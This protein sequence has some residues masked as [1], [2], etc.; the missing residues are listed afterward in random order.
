MTNIKPGA[1]L[2]KEV[3]VK[4]TGTLEASYNLIWQ[5]LNNGITNDEMVMSATCE[6]QN[7]S[8]T[9][10]GTCEGLSETA[11]GDN[12]I[13]K[14]ITIESG[15]THKY[16]ITIT[17]KDT[18]AEQNYNQGKSFTGVLG[19]KE[20]NP[21]EVEVLNCTFDG[22]MVQGAEYVNGQY[23]YRYKQKGSS[24]FSTKLSWANM[25]VDGWGVQL[26]DKASTNPVTSKICTYINNKPVVSMSTMFLYSNATSIDL[27]SFDTSDVTDMFD[28]F[29]K[30]K[31]TVLDV[32]N[33]DTSKVTNMCGMFS[34]TDALEIKGL[35]NFNTSNVTN[36]C[37]MFSSSQAKA[38]NLSN[39]DTSNVRNMNS[40]FSDS[41]ATEIKGLDKFNTSNVTDMEYMF[42]GSKLTTIDL[43]NFDTSNVTIMSY[44]FNASAA[45]TIDLS[46]FNTNKVE[47]MDHMFSNCTSLKTIFASDKFVT[48]QLPTM[49]DMG[50]NQVNTDLFSGSTNL[51]GGN[52]TKFNSSY[53]DRTYARIDTDSTPGYF[54]LKNN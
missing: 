33:F 6:R 30:S 45:T 7:N 10:E 16:V 9:V 50:Y 2:T 25:N 48:A 39:F 22:D 40:M 47:R 18:N 19:V 37:T 11:I 15:I 20:Y 34:G 41:L 38:L 3:S 49:D 4:N 14:N 35:E 21:N 42:Y 36:M 5:E 29:S 43:S 17:F 28:M 32:S 26:T 46:S 54:T 31:A 13:K 44:M 27:S 24:S 52:G 23:T 1:S 8:G 53:I 51:V 12:N